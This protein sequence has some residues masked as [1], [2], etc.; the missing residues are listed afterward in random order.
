MA[1]QVIHADVAAYAT[2][3]STFESRNLLKKYLKVIDDE[4]GYMDFLDLTGRREITK[5]PEFSN[6]TESSLFKPG[7]AVG[8]TTAG[9]ANTAVTIVF[10]GTTGVKPF[11]SEVIMFKDF[12]KGYIASVTASSANWSCSVKPVGTGN[13]I[14]A[15]ADGETIIFTG[16]AQGEGSELTDMLR[17]PTST[18]R[19]NNIQLF[20]TKTAVTD[21]AGSTEYEIP[22]RGSSYIVNKVKYQQYINHRIQVA[23]ELLTSVKGTTTDAAGNKVWFT[24]GLRPQIKSAG[25]SLATAATDVFNV[26]A[27]M[28]AMSIALDNAGSTCMEYLMFAGQTFDNA[29]TDNSLTNTSLTGGAVSYAAY[30][31]NKEIALAFGV[32]QMSYGGRTVFKNRMRLAEHSGMFGA[33]GYTLK[34]EAFILPT[35]RV[36]TADDS[37][38]IDRMRVR[39]MGFEGNQERYHEVETGAFSAARNNA[40]RNKTLDIMSNEAVE[41]AGIEHFMIMNLA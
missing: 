20:T 10:N 12:K 39:F 41:L 35:D 3:S 1:A 17:N 23:N 33:T 18:L 9:A 13:I 4:W 34:R 2:L 27:D 26:V 5:T 25:I 31:G 40:K 16:N 28:R 6:I 30:N 32:S 19:T 21:I 38:T 24:S 29:V 7:F 14:P 11:V 37:G 8:A 22:F 36:K 15:V